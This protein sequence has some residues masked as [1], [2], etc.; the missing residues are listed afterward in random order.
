[1]TRTVTVKKVTGGWR[2]YVYGA[3]D[4]DRNRGAGGSANP[5]TCS[6]E[7]VT[8]VQ[9]AF[10]E[11][12]ELKRRLWHLQRISESGRS[13]SGCERQTDAGEGTRYDTKRT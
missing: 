12:S 3:G 7:E 8:Q 5:V 13:G 9:R 10:P 1:M 11:H 4:R 2:V 6:G